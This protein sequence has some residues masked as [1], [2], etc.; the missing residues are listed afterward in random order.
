MCYSK[1][2]ENPVKYNTFFTVIQLF[3]VFLLN[4]VFDGYEVT[5]PCRMGT[6][7]IRGVK[8]KIKI[9]ENGKVKGLSI[10]W[11][12]TKKLWE[13][14][15]QAREEKKVV[16]NTNE[17]SSGIRYKFVWGKNRVLTSFKTLYSLRMC[18]ANKR[19]F[20]RLVKQEN[21]EYLTV[22]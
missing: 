18:R 19:E 2:V 11:P 14:N 8:Q 9:D 10:N 3:F 16:Y 22:N 4:K 21:R 5:L 12:Q 20:S 7:Y 1:E 15:A 17:H 13:S 6:L